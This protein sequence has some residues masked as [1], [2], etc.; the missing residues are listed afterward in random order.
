[1]AHNREVV[2]RRRATD[3]KPPIAKQ[4]SMDIGTNIAHRSYADV[5]KNRVDSEGRKTDHLSYDA[6]QKIQPSLVFTIPE[7]QFKWLHNCFVGETFAEEQIPVLQDYLWMEGDEQ[8]L[9]LRIEDME[10]R[11]RAASETRKKENEEDV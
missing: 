11:D 8:E 6:A 3:H 10:A 2:P 1:M 4:R 9:L 7:D 5:M